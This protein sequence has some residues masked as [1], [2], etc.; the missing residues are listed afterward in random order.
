MMVWPWWQVN[1]VSNLVRQR[2][3]PDNRQTR[4]TGE[5]PSL[6]RPAITDPSWAVETGDGG[7][8]MT[9]CQARLSGLRTFGG[10]AGCSD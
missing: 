7:W 4:F 8:F 10:R 5:G 6:G 3:Q 9:V 2:E 1:L